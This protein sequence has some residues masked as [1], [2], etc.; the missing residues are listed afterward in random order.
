MKP[1]AEV[2]LT[3]KEADFLMERGI[4]PLASLKNQAVLLVRFQSI[5]Q[6]AAA[7]SG[8]WCGAGW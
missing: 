6:P 2:L 4:M 3:E 8:R 1:C 5:A 7:L